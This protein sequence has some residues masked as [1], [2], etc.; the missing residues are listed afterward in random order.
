MH[1]ANNYRNRFDALLAGKMEP[2]PRT[3][4][5]PNSSNHLRFFCR[6]PDQVWNN[7]N[8]T[9]GKLLQVS[10]D[11]FFRLGGA[12]INN[13]P[14]LL[15]AKDEPDDPQESCWGITD[16]IPPAG[17]N[18]GKATCEISFEIIEPLLNP[19]INT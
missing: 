2:I 11:I 19:A 6:S 7:R 3:D 1:C 10:N 18:E 13:P 9:Q 4:L 14:S 8:A 17:M 15:R 5:S 12:Y 16:R